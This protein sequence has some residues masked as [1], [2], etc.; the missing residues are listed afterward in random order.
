MTRSHTR[1]Q[2][3]GLRR[4]AS[5]FIVVTAVALATP[6]VAAAQQPDTVSR[7]TTHTVKTGDTLWDLARVYLGDPF[8][9]PEIYR[10]NT[11]IVEDPHWIYPGEVLRLPGI[12]GLEPS[13]VAELTPSEPGVDEAPIE[14]TGPTSFRRAER[15]RAVASQREGGLTIP[16]GP[17]VRAWEFYAAPFVPSRDARRGSGKIVGSTEISGIGSNTERSWLQPHERVYV[18]VPRSTTPS[19]GDRYIAYK[20]GP[21]LSGIGQ[22]VIPTAVLVVEKPG[23]GEA[24][25]ARVERLFGDV[26]VGHML[27]AFESFTPPPAA[28]LTPIEFGVDTRIAW[29]MNE[30]DL[31]SLQSYL[32]IN[33]KSGDGVKPGDEFHVYRGAVN[34][35]GDKLPAEQIAVARAVRV[36]DDA[37]TLIVTGQRHPAIRVGARTRLTARMP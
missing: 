13:V 2:D 26:Q 32:V 18:R 21:D 31:A 35:A 9:W 12:G 22:L 8:L 17:A 33:A 29:V 11:N 23:N 7:P 25:I 14:S 1:S 10:I 30:P 5:V 15:R 4:S 6:A 20:L 16:A 37:T 36:T 24:T 3:S 34:Q 28:T 27:M 19:T